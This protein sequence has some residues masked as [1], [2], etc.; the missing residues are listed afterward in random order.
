MASII[1][2]NYFVGEINLPHTGSEDGYAVVDQ[3]INRYEQEYL[4]SVL[5]YDLWKAFTN[6]IAATEP[7]QKWI[8]LRDGKEFTNLSG[9][10]T[11]WMG[12]KNS[13]LKSPIACY[14]YFHFMED[15]VT[16]TAFIGEVKPSAENA[17]Q[18]SP[19]AKM[20]NAWNR[21]AEM[22]D[23]LYDF[24]RANE[25]TYPEFQNH[26]APRWKRYKKIN[27]FGI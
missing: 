2:Y 1:D 25:D 26:P 14:V 10:N 21:M 6:G 19:S 24:L 20:M 3:F 22:T 12:F 5:G 4:Q 11:K 17:T 8:D 27:L 23:I 16:D 9:Y 7:E 13:E 15:R 18:A